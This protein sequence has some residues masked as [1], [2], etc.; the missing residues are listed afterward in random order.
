MISLS[1][2]GN[3]IYNGGKNSLKLPT[4]KNSTIEKIELRDDK[5]NKGKDKRS[6]A[7]EGVNRSK[8]ENSVKRLHPYYPVRV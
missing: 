4:A 5:E 2:E 6:I 8:S 7:S 1:P 3:A